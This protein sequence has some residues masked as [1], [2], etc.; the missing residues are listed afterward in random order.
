M[1]AAPNDASYVWD[2]VELVVY[3]AK[4][5]IVEGYPESISSLSSYDVVSRR[6]WRWEDV[7]YSPSPDDYSSM[8]TCE[9]TA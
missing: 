4:N 3:D 8:M 5:T 2:D 9:I 7:F 6:L 1:I